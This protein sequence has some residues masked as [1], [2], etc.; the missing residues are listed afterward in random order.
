MATTSSRGP[1]YGLHG[2]KPEIGAPGAS[3]SAEVGTGTGTTAFGGTSGAAPMV[4]GAAALLLQAHP[5]RSPMQIKAML[6]NRAETS[7]D[8]HP[9]LYPG[10]K[11]P[12]TRIGAGELR[13]DRSLG[14]TA[15]AWDADALS[16][17]LSFG[18]VEAA[19]LVV[20]ERTLTVQDFSG[21]G[22]HFRLDHDYRY[23]DDEA[24]RA[25]RLL[26]PRSVYVPANGSAK[27]KVRM[28][29]DPSKLPDWTLDG[30]ANGGNGQLLNLL[31]VDGFVTLSSRSET[32]SLPWHVLPRKA[33][34]T[35]AAPTWGGRHGKYAKDVL[36]LVNVGADTGEFDLFSLTGTSA[37]GGL[38]P[39]PAAGENYAL[40]DLKS[41]GVR[42]LADAGAL[43]FA[44]ATHGR[45]S[46]PVYPGGFEVD[47]DTNGDG[48][49]DF[50]VFQQELG[51]FA[52]TGSSVV[53]VQSAS[54]GAASAYYYNDADLNSGNVIYT[55]PLA[56][57]GITPDMPIGFDVYAYDNYF[58]GFL[59]DVVGGMRFTPAS[60]RYS[61]AGDDG[62]SGAVGRRG[63]LK[64]PYARATVDDAGSTESGLL[65][66]YRRNAAPESQEVRLD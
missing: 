15:V 35:W 11:A 39:A 49:P 51:G 52:A 27:V 25:V 31:E 61:A 22:R 54:T 16:A 41:V 38:L 48:V 53:Y 21:S 40:V 64:V 59:T 24:A 20:L 55:V 18:A 42:Y 29:I 14:A 34:L 10:Q 37:E 26:M 45:R 66:M 58:S 47:I 19:Q 5:A 32:L 23:T 6:M 30:G 65:L 9:V 60:P 17:S 57:L 4:S 50:Y 36:N 13:V 56:A 44:I 12:I 2:I 63:S 46:H 7:I 43:Q 33:A 62:P 1:S 8:T 28:L 3:V